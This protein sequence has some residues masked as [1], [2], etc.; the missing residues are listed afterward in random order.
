MRVAKALPENIRMVS[1]PERKFDCRSAIPGVGGLE[2]T[3]V[4]DLEVTPFS[5]ESLGSTGLTDDE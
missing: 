3:G 2:G 4:A 5:L 1:I